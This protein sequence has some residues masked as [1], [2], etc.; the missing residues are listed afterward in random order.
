V[1]PARTATFGG[2]D[3]F[4]Q[5]SS[6]CAIPVAELEWRYSAS[7]GPG[8]Q[9][10]NRSNTRVEITFDIQNSPSLS[11]WERSK[12]IERFGTEL[13]VVAADE[14]SQLRNRELAVERMTARLAS[15]LV[16]QRSRRA[17]KPSRGAKQRRLTNKKQRSQTKANRRKPTRDD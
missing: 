1:E 13:R 10:A 5:V 9:H 11:A 4:M 6:S 8:G 3:E 12:M 17:T 7:G 15:A 14:R 2:V 16:V